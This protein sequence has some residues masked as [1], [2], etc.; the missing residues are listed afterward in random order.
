MCDTVYGTTLPGKRKASVNVEGATCSLVTGSEKLEGCKAALV[1]FNCLLLP[2]P[3][4]A[5]VGGWVVVAVGVRRW[6]AGTKPY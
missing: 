5:R 6:L 3:A 1:S 2:L 4:W